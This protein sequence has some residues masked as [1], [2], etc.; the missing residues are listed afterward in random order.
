M[1]SIIINVN[2][3]LTF[4]ILLSPSGII[5][6]NTNCDFKALGFI[7]PRYI[8]QIFAAGF[9]LFLLS[10]NLDGFLLPLGFL[11]P[12]LVRFVNFLCSMGW[13]FSRRFWQIFNLTS[14]FSGTDFAF[15]SFCLYISWYPFVA[16]LVTFLNYSW[17]WERL[18]EAKGMDFGLMDE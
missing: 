2:Q 13:W 11:L 3:W 1:S 15:L 12:D 16:V 14:G 4:H 18:C 6:E 17:V 10:H 5:E 7:I 8:A 9:L